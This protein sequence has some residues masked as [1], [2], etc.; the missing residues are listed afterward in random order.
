MWARPSKRW[1]RG[2]C[3][4][5]NG[6]FL[7]SYINHISTRHYGHRREIE[8]LSSPLGRHFGEFA[9]QLFWQVLLLFPLFGTHWTIKKSPDGLNNSRW[10]LRQLAIMIINIV[11]CLLNNNNQDNNNHRRRLRLRQLAASNHWQGRGRATWTA[12]KE[13]AE[14]N[15]FLWFCFC[16]LV[17][18][19]ANMK[20][21]QGCQSSDKVSH[22]GRHT[23]I[24]NIIFP[25]RK[26]YRQL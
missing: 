12:W 14:E 15:S 2:I 1:G 8:T 6:L 22:P 21:T 26:A 4:L 9:F 19:C 17:T 3:V 24:K 13:V 11:Y 20:R 18:R 23:G 5:W 10:R 25:P 16:F 7:K